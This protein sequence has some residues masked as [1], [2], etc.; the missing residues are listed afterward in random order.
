MATQ[1][2]HLHRPHP[3]LRPSS[4]AVASISPKDVRQLTSVRP[5]H[6]PQA[7]E[8][9]RHEVA[10]AYS[11]LGRPP[12]DV[13]ETYRQLCHDVYERAGTTLAFGA[14]TRCG[15]AEDLS[16][17]Y[18]IIFARTDGTTP[19]PI[20]AMN[21]M[22]VFPDWPHRREGL[23]DNCIAEFSHLVVREAYRTPA[24][25]ADHI[26]AFLVR[27]LYDAV[28]DV[29]RERGVRVLYGIARETVVSI[30]QQANVPLVRVPT[31]QP[32][33]DDRDNR[34]VFERY[35]RYW[36]RSDP[37]RLYRSLVPPLP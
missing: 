23:S 3:S 25:R 12:V 5:I 17:T 10:L 26:P 1:H 2:H 15:D 7:L 11:Q 35:N 33:F 20:D 16:A 18:R 9:V 8:R 36:Q 6:E 21:L 19:Q 28:V 24:M 37:P 32:R 4:G 13:S 22:D 34:M 14:F 30:L 31:S 29:M 27:C